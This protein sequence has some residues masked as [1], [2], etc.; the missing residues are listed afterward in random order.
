MVRREVGS[1]E[2]G[3]APT[4]PAPHA[5]LRL[6][7]C[8]RLT[9]A[10]AHFCRQATHGAARSHASSRRLMRLRAPR[11]TLVRLDGHIQLR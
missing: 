9:R 5:L 6:Y 2:Y 3:G 11:S 4:T 8:S 1:I 7:S 10:R